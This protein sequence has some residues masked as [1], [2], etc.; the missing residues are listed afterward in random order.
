[1]ANDV[2]GRYAEAL[3][4]LSKEND[5]VAE[6]KEEAEV[7]LAEFQANPEL[8]WFFRA[9][10]IS[11]DEKKELIGRCFESFLPETVN[12]LKLLVD[13][14]RMYYLR[15]ILEEFIRR[16]DEELGIETAVVSSA[17]KLDESQLAKIRAALEKK[18][19]KQVK[20]INRIDE[21]LIA[22]IKVTAGTTVTDV[23]VARQIEEMK[24]SLL[25]GGIR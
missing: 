4:Q 3:F 9:V 10:Q 19:G 6:R 20:L 24:E 12:F 11:R 16:S 5:Q 2:A 23:S 13:K 7:I 18:T 14:D 25:K 22:G 21:S 8:A 17:R 15:P 1:M